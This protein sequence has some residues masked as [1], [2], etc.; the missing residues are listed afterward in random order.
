MQSVIQGK[1]KLS[2]LHKIN[3]K[4]ND[5]LHLNLVHNIFILLDLNL[6]VHETVEFPLFSSKAPSFHRYIGLKYQV[7]YI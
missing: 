2:K 5:M 3:S 1:L 7:V 4:N 6:A